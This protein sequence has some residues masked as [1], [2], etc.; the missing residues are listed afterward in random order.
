M[1]VDQEMIAMAMKAFFTSV[2]LLST[3]ELRYSRST[4]LQCIRVAVTVADAVM[5]SVTVRGTA[6]VRV[7]AIIGL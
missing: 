2:S 6:T 5:V 3:R 7:T 1:E 4:H